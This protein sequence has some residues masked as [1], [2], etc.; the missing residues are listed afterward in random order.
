MYGNTR[1]LAEKMAEKIK[2]AGIAPV[3]IH[4]AHFED[5]S[6]MISD[7]FRYKGL[8]IGSPTYSL[9]LFPPVAAF[10]RAMEVREI[11]NKVMS[12]FGSYAWVP[13]A[14][15]ELDFIAANNKWNIA[16]K[17]TM[18]LAMSEKSAAELDSFIADFI[19]AYKQ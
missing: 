1:A 12:I 9:T 14:L 19:E 2:E 11:K 7:A 13:A 5:L 8:I 18:N 15:K 3:K 16:S 17:M 4:E 10:V 6:F